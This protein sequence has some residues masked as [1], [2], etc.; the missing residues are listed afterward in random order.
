[1]LMLVAI[2]VVVAADVESF[3]FWNTFQCCCSHGSRATYAV[4]R[5]SPRVGLTVAIDTTVFA[6]L[7]LPIKLRECPLDCHR[8]KCFE[9]STATD[10]D[11]NKARIFCRSETSQCQ[12]VLIVYPI[13]GKL[14][15][16]QRSHKANL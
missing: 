16:T 3:V 6:F 4:H 14:I 1:M 8:P 9:S 11:F 2:I 12:K 7:P 13:T 15:A 10:K 5:R